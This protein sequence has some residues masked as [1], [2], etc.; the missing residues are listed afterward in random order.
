MHVGLALLDLYNAWGETRVTVAGET[1][2]EIKKS[3]SI[4]MHAYSSVF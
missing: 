2:R 4:K 1:Q 3:K